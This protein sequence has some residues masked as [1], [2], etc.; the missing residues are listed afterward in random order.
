MRGRPDIFTALTPPDAHPRLTP[1]TLLAAEATLLAGLARQWAEEVWRLWIPH[2]AQVR[3][4]NLAL[5]PHRVR[6]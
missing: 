2:H 1:R 4:W 5:V 6:P 3:A